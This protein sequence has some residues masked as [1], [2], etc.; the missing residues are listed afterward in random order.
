MRQTLTDPLRKPRHL[1]KADEETVLSNT[2]NIQVRDKKEFKPGRNCQRCNIENGLK[3]D[4]Q[5]Q[6][7]IPMC[8]LE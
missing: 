5:R 8:N 3:Q 7:Y 4:I 6:G 1:T 2:L